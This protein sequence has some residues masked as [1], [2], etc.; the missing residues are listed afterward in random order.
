MSEWQHGE[1]ILEKGWERV[2]INKIV[3]W[4]S[5]DNEG[6][7]EGKPKM[8]MVAVRVRVR[9]SFIRLIVGTR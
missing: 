4:I 3:N 2:R 5:N 6:E 9:T 8:H 1:H 7:I